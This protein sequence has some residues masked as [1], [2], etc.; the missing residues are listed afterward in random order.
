M[1]EGV[2]RKLIKERSL[3]NISVSSAGT[4]G[5][6]TFKIFGALE[7]VL[8][9]NDINYEGHV[10]TPLTRELILA[11]DLILVMEEHHRQKVL[12]LAP[13]AKD[14]VHLLTEFAGAMPRDIPD[15][16]GQPKKVYESSFKE[17]KGLVEKTLDR[18]R[19][20]K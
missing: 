3:K 5:N 10:S 13:E 17:I 18:L 2:A 7:D 14:K 20:I 1:A 6:P 4:I 16:I 19:G 15:P 9:E 11:S 8:K 12:E